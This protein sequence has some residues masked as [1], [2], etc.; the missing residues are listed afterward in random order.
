MILL[1]IFIMNRVEHV[2]IF[3]LFLMTIY[4]KFKYHWSADYICL[5]SPVLIKYGLVDFWS[6]LRKRG[7]TAL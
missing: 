6:S 7:P 5:P 1:L 3:Q 4:E 2:F